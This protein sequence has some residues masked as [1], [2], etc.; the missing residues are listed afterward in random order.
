MATCGMVIVTL[1]SIQVLMELMK[2]SDLRGSRTQAD[3]F[4]YM[5]SLLN[6]ERRFWFFRPLD[7]FP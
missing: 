1:A 7:E 5:H 6:I 4:K 2:R 3:E